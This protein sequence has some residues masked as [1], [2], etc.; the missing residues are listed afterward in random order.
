M[1]GVGATFS[2]G[3]SAGSGGGARPLGTAPV[4]TIQV[5][6]DMGRIL[7]GS[8]HGVHEWMSAPFAQTRDMAST[9]VFSVSVSGSGVRDVGK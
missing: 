5:G 1:P 2:G 7:P 3:G 8:L 9:I 6:Y 4:E